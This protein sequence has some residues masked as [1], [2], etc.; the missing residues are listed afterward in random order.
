MKPFP[1]V[2]R[3]RTIQQNYQNEAFELLLARFDR[4]DE[5]NKAI[6]DGLK[7]H[8][9]DD[10]KVAAQVQKHGTYWALLIGLGGPLVLGIVAWFQGLF[11]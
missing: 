10:L 8:I 6:K 1:K 9:K 7:D 11:K 2:K 4:V 3:K 5:D